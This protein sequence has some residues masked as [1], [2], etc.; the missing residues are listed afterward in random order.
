MNMSN[1]GEL[2]VSYKYHSSLNNR[3]IIQEVF[4]AVKVVLQ[5]ID[6][7]RV[8]LQEQ[9]AVIYLN[10]SNAV[11]GTLNTFSGTISCTTVDFKIVVGT[12]IKLMAS[13]VIVAHNHPSGKM[14]PSEQDIQ[15]T[16]RLKIALEVMDISLLDHIIIGPEDRYCCFSELNLI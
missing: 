11:I 9:F 1:L 3:P 16:N 8:G 7:E 13:A 2:S 14:M 12:A 6:Q 4:D 15:L 5:V 10:R